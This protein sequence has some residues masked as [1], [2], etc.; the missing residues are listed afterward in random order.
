[1]DHAWPL[2]ERRQATL[3]SCEGA[4]IEHRRPLSITDI[5]AQS[6]PD[7]SAKEAEVSL[8][9]MSSMPAPMANAL[10]SS[11]IVDPADQ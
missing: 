6:A 7:T 1:M 9:S 11:A 5:L 3:V 4:A 8:A 10:A 2:A